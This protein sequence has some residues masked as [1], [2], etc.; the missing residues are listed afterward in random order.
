MKN[1]LWLITDD[2]WRAHLSRIQSTQASLQAATQQPIDI[3]EE[4]TLQLNAPQIKALR[5]S[6][7]ISD[8]DEAQRPFQYLVEVVKNVA[9]ITIEGPLVA[10]EAWYNRFLGVVSYGE[11]I[12][13]V[14]ELSDLATNGE[15]DTVVMNM[16]TPGGSV[17]GIDEAS[18]AFDMLGQQVTLLAHADTQMTSGG[19]W[20][21][22][23]AARIT[24]NRMSVVGSIGVIAISVSHHRR[25]KEM[26]IDVEV[27]RSGSEKAL[28]HP[29]EPLS[30][31]AREIRQETMDLVH[32]EFKQRIGEG[33]GL[34]LSQVA[35]IS[36]GRSWMAMQ[37]TPGPLVDELS[38]LE[39]VVA[40][41]VA[42]HNPRS[43][44][45]G[46]RLADRAVL[47]KGEGANDMK[48]KIL[49]EKGVAAVAAGM[50]KLAA[51]ADA[52][53]YTIEEVNEADPAVTD[54][55]VVEGE[56]DAVTD[57]PAGD[58][59]AS[60][61]DAPNTDK[62]DT[63]AVAA[64]VNESVLAA[65]LTELRTENKQLIR[66]Q[67][68]AE[69]TIEGLQAKVDDAESRAQISATAISTLESIASE[70]MNRMEV[71]LGV[72]TTEGAK[73][74]ALVERYS[75]VK[76]RFEAAFRIGAQSRVPTAEN[77]LD[78]RSTDELSQRLE[79]GGQH[80]N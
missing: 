29:Y 74:A 57:L 67:A 30:D 46:M 19:A 58:D 40:R 18:R 60:V 54:V 48:I 32:G 27:M 20:L 3:S 59:P 36:T 28:G 50:D 69:L 45:L 39:Q 65:Q 11:L 72:T 43:S 53:M 15:I 44:S 22:A 63:P 75:S 77:I 49:N 73:G 41:R 6:L 62:P 64:P 5:E 17:A 24:A 4:G 7:S 52:S 38:T 14:E 37:V 8:D 2:G 33:R 55:V 79:R 78:Q 26:G 9:V 68:K 66:A 23:K 47:I 31:R 1:N 35:E 16:R 61:E 56:G 34:N 12:S 51:L 70:A 10:E 25:L 13:A 71:A 42:V 21:T 76:T 80:I